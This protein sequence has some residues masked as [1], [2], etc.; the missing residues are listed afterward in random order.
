[1]NQQKIGEFLKRLR[2]EKGLTQEQLAEKFYVSSR[3]VSRWETGSNMPDVGT[4]IEL[5]DFYDVDI[6]EIIDGERKSEM[7]DKETKDTLKKVAA[8]ATEQEKGVQSRVVYAALGISIALFVSTILFSGEYTGLLYGIIPEDICFII[9]VFVYG[10]AAC[11]LIFYLR[12]R[13]FMEKPTTEPEKTVVATVASKEVR[14]GTNRSGRSMMGYSFVVNFQ[15]ED[16]E[17]LELYAYEIEFGGLKE[18]MQGVL[19]YKG[20][21]FVDF[22]EK[23]GL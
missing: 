2:R 19:T 18:G 20:R 1:M 13:W 6:R 14:E 9:L 10:V 12:V 15:T 21:Y 17:N 11:S 8:Y 7:M 5:A 4:L 16:G 23:T 3:T 22:N